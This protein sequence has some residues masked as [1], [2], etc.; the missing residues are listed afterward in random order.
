VSTSRRPGGDPLFVARDL[1]FGYG[2]RAVLSAV[3]MTVREGEFWFLLGRNGSGKTT[4]LRGILGLLSPL[5]GTIERRSG[6]EA[7][8]QLGFVPQRC[9]INPAL[10]TTVREFVSLG[11]VGI[12]ASRS[13]RSA[14]LRW[15]L[16]RTDLEG[17]ARADYWALSGGQRQRALVA[18]ALVRRPRVLVL[19]E[20]TEGFDL[21]TEEGLLRTLADLHRERGTTILFVTHKLSVAERHAS[22]VALFDRGSVVA[23]PRA[24]VLRLERTQAV[25]GAPLAATP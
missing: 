3:D 11:C 8:E 24:E 16:E 4:L 22:H 13:E 2:G 1:A 7:R 14:N 25:F 17:L 19:D 23:G 10:P 5:S 21:R 9:E 12:R 20:P 6:R 18:R 15:A